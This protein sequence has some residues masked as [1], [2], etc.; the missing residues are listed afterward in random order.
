MNR[1]PQ[2]SHRRVRGSG[3]VMEPLCVTIAG[4]VTVVSSHAIGGAE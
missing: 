3:V 4:L 1:K 2:A